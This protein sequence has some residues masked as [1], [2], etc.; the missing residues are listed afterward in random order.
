MLYDEVLI[1]IET[2]MSQNKT[3]QVRKELR[4]LCVRHMHM[5]GKNNASSTTCINAMMIIQELQDSIISRDA[6]IG[7][8]ID[9]QTQV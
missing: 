4:S 1:T 2:L 8:L 5:S 3:E 9:L 7:A 6:T